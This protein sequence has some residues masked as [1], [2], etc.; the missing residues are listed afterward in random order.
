MGRTSIRKKFKMKVA[1]LSGLAFQANAFTISE[2]EANQILARNRREN[3]Q[4]NE[5][6]QFFG[7]VEGADD[8]ERECIEERCNDEE[9]DEVYDWETGFVKNSGKASIPK[10]VLQPCV[11][12]DRSMES[13]EKAR[14]VRIRQCIDIMQAELNK[15][16]WVSSTETPVTQPRGMEIE[17]GSDRS[18][19]TTLIV[20]SINLTVEPKSDDF[21]PKSFD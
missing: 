16:H 19:D 12:Q 1:L 17:Y 14:T 20:T 7:L 4:I 9:L 21:G 10:E 15:T 5:N 11:E 2:K 18:E 6:S 3:P 8:L 13:E